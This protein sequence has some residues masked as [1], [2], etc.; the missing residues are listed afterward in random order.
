MTKDYKGRLWIGCTVILGILLAT[1]LLKGCALDPFEEFETPFNRDPNESLLDITTTY[2]ELSP[3]GEYSEEYVVESGEKNE[4]FFAQGGGCILRPIREVWAMMHNM[5]LMLWEDTTRFTVNQGSPPSGSSHH[6]KINYVVEQSIGGASW[7]MDWFHSVTWG[8][9]AQPGQVLVNYQKT[10]GTTHIKIWEGS[11]LLEEV[12]EKVTGFAAI[13]N[14]KGSSLSGIDVS[15]PL[16]AV[17]D[18]YDKLRTKSDRFSDR[19][20][21]PNY[22][23]INP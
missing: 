23:A 20:K 21:E 4:V 12:D 13:D 11:I 22:E 2:C 3:D 19:N 5:D 15:K 1:P 18:L 7:T 16:G 8:T 9:L 17:K 10:A 6:Y 14:I